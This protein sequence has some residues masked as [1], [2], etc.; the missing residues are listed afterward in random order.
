MP[1]KSIDN[2]RPSAPSG[3]ES[4]AALAGSP[5]RDVVSGDTGAADTETSRASEQF[6]VSGTSERPLKRPRSSALES[7]LGDTDRRKQIIETEL[8]PWRMICALEIESQTG[9]AFVGTGWFAGPRTVITAGHC[10]FDPVE[11]G[12][13]AKKITVIPGRNVDKKPF[14]S[15]SSSSF[16]TTDRWQEAQEADFDY[17]VIHLSSDL[18][19]GIGSFSVGVLTDEALKNRLVNVSGY[20]FE[21]G[22]GKAQYFHANRVKAVTN[23]RIFYDIDTMGGQSGSP[24][25][26]YE[27][28]DKKKPIVVA[29]HAYGIGGVPTNL[30]VVANSGPRVLPEVLEVIRGWITRGNT[31]SAAA[32][33]TAAAAGAGAGAAGGTV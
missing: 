28:E 15:A 13:W 33:G 2:P 10:V 21:P 12:G 20:P 29:I 25:W 27:D 9:A 23:R 11:L 31:E 18:G 14:K 22:E 16:S 26:A 17:G 8:T 19:A 30:N 5:Q 7:I 24:V 1:L 4:A 3:R 32:A 6:L